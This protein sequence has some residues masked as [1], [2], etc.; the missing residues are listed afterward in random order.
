MFLGIVV[1]LMMILKLLLQH[2]LMF[3]FGKKKHFGQHTIKVVAFDVAGNQA[4]DRIV[5]WKFF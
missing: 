1:M 3:G 5:V 2:R 4:E